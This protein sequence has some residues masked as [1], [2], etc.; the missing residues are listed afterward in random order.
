MSEDDYSGEGEDEGDG[1]ESYYCETT[2]R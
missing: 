2:H 1:E